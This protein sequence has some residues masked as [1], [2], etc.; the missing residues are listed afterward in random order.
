VDSDAAVGQRYRIE[1]ALPV[2]TARALLVTAG[3]RRRAD[4]CMHVADAALAACRERG[5]PVLVTNIIAERVLVL[6][7][8]QRRERFAESENIV[9]R[10]TTGREV[11][12]EALALHHILALP[13]IDAVVAD[14]RADNFLNRY[15][16]GF[17]GGYR[18]LGARADYLGR[19]VLRIDKQDKGRL[20]FDVAA[21]GA[22]L[23]ELIVESSH[24]DPIGAARR[25]AEGLAAKY[26]LEV[27]VTS[28]PTL[29]AR[30][31]DEPPVSVAFAAVDVPIGIVEA[32]VGVGPAPLVW[33]GGDFL[34]SNAALDAV[35]RRAAASLGAFGEL[36]E[37]VL[38]PLVATPL[39][40]ARPEDLLMALRGAASR[41]RA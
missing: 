33:L 28:L 10:R 31:A 16:R 24:A 36:D 32:G 26:F 9:R 2:G 41:S 34:A 18:K 1:M 25:F 7:A 40:G 29:A 19:D 3:V 11:L 8:R 5:S 4:D 12:V 37:R 17:L 23:V 15:A 38:E 27:E 6:G 13:S 21:D 35:A 39:E 14:A 22:A 30:V 20:G